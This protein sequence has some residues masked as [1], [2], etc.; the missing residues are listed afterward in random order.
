MEIKDFL[1]LLKVM[2]KVISY[3]KN[4]LVTLD[5]FIGQSKTIDALKISI[6]AA[7]MRMEPLGHILLTGPEGC[8]KNTLADAIAYECDA[9]IKRINIKDFRKEGDLGPTY[10]NLSEGSILIIEEIDEISQDLVNF[11]CSVME[12]AH[13][14]ITIG[15]GP[16]ARSVELDFPK[17][18]VIGIAET[19]HKLPKK[20]AQCFYIDAKF[21]K[22][23]EDELFVL[24]KKWC[25]FNN[26]EIID[27]AATKIAIYSEGSSKLLHS[28]MKRARDFADVYNKGIINID[29]IDRT[30][31]NLSNKDFIISEV[32]E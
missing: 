32:C 14:A 15:K 2:Q 31:A 25:S 20:L 18:T 11:L 21:T 22:Y 16:S 24:A 10:I 19:T 30:I 9:E 1:N 23:S 17:I 29:I 27:E 4:Q 3:M 6:A 28:A 7:K 26:S 5:E 13:A 12:D 8:G